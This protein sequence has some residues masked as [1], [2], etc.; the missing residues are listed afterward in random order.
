MLHT[1]LRSEIA[2]TLAVTGLLSAALFLT[3]GFLHL[4][5]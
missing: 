3:V 5:A 1:I 2:Q 4:V